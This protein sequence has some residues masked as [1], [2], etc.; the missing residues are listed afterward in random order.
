VGQLA[1]VRVGEVIET[2][3]GAL[4]VTHGVD[5]I[6]HVATVRGI[7]AGQ[8]FKADLDDLALCTKNVLTMAHVKNQRFQRIK[9]LFGR[10]NCESILIPIIGAG[11][12]GLQPAVVVPQLISAAMR[13]YQDNPQTTLKEI[14]FLAF[15]GAHKS[16]CDRELHRLLDQ[17]IIKRTE[18]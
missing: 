2:T 14:Y 8:G 11:D 16:A 15:T 5:R 6:L 7:G 3:A 1:R 9:E 17:G 18:S 13:Y 10:K 4:T 12:G